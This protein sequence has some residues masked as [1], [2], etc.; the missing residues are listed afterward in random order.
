MSFLYRRKLRHSGRCSINCLGLLK[1]LV[2]NPSLHDLT[3]LTKSSMSA[4]G[5]L[6]SP[7]TLPQSYIGGKEKSEHKCNE[8]IMNGNMGG[9]NYHLLDTC[10]ALW[11]YRR[12]WPI[13]TT[14]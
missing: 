9:S 4:L 13:L 8:R 1:Q 2:S 12:N 11:V 7:S 5:L 10:F 6:Q 14:L 3:L